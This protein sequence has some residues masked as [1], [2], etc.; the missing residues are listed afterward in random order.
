MLLSSLGFFLFLLPFVFLL[1]LI[2]NYVSFLLQLADT[3]EQVHEFE[4]AASLWALVS[5]PTFSIFGLLFFSINVSVIEHMDAN[6]VGHGIVHLFSLTELKCKV[7][8]ILFL[9]TPLRVFFKPIEKQVSRVVVDISINGH[10]TE[11][12]AVVHDVVSRPVFLKF[13]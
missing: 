4:V 6:E 2:V 11:L 1:D 8:I 10:Q 13:N 3:S 5:Q 9:L 12:L 7:F